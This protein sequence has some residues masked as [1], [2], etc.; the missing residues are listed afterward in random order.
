MP[1]YHR[2][3]IVSVGPDESIMV[4]VYS[5]EACTDLSITSLKYKGQNDIT[6][7]SDKNGANIA[8]NETLYFYVEDDMD[9]KVRADATPTGLIPKGS[10]VW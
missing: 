3:A 8:G 10:G 6:R 5:D 7:F 4:R 2:G 1:L 9:G